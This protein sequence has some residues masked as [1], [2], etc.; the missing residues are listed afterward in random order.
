MGSDLREKSG[1]VFAAD[2]LVPEVPDP[3]W[4]P[5]LRI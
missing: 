3:I 2:D 5:W 1:I 4:G